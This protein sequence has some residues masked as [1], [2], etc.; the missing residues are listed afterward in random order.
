MP[1][2]QA[3][4]ILGPGAVIYSDKYDIPVLSGIAFKVFLRFNL[5]DGFFSRAVVLKL[6]QNKRLSP[7]YRLIH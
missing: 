4:V 3:L 1:F 6:N 2:N 7:C 5:C